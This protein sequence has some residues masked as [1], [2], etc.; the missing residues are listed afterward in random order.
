MTDLPYRAWA[1]IHLAALERNLRT[2]RSALP[3]RV[4]FVAVVKADAYGHGMYHTVSRLMHSGVDLLAVANL[5]E[6]ASIREIGSGWPILLLSAIT[7]SEDPVLWEYDVIPTLSSMD[8]LKRWKLWARRL[9][10]PLSVHLKVDTGMGRLGVWYE[11]AIHLLNAVLESSP[12]IKLEGIFT[13]FSSADSDLEFTAVQRARLLGVLKQLP[14]HTPD[15]LLHADNSAGIDTFSFDGPFNAVRIGLL[16]FGISPH[17]QSML[18]GITVE[19]V[20]SFHCRLSLV[21]TLPAGA[22]VSYGGTFTCQ[23]AMKIG[24]LSAGYADGIPVSL[25]NRGEVLVRATRCPILGRVTMDQT[26]IDLSHCTEAQAGDQ[27][28]LIGKSGDDEI[29]ATDFAQKADSI[30]WEVLVSISKR[31]PRIY[32]TVR[33]TESRI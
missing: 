20:L 19:P 25:S 15:I 14:A 17:R 7:P 5:S 8:E 6:A 26:I 13:H 27:V 21:K 1:E 24:V 2:I 33:G 12:E 22:H 3:N 18:S 9:K 4:R 29:S 28:T 30:P 10:R 11:E 31:V 32:R 16:Q 23:S